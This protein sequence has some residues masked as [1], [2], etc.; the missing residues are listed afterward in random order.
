MLLD[1]DE[2]VLFIDETGTANPKDTVSPYYILLGCVVKEGERLKLKGVAHNIKYKHWNDVDVV[3]HS[4]EIG[5]KQNH[6]SIFKNKKV[7]DEFLDDLEHYLFKRDFLLQYVLI[8]KDE[9]RKKNWND[10]KIYKETSDELI[11]NFIL[12]LMSRNA[13]GKIV[14]ESASA[15]KDIYFM[16]SLSQYLSSGIPTA[17]VSHT[18]VKDTLTSISFVTKNNFDTEEQ[19]ADL[20]AY[21]AKCHYMQQNKIKTFTQRYERLMM[22]TLA[23][24]LI[25]KSTVPVI[26]PQYAKHIKSQVRLP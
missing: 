25:T 23:A 3:L 19:L 21:A 10:V 9:A 22:K 8:D 1:R 4:A 18:Q 13:K 15:E 7:F 16:K 14:V 12:F 26:K 2:Y 24:R 17:G 6:F 5:R 11:R 20:F